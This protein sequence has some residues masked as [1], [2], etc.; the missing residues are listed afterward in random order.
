MRKPIFY[1]IKDE[2]TDE[3][4]RHLAR[5]SE[6]ELSD[7]D[8]EH[9][10]WEFNSLLD[11]VWKLQEIDTEWVEKMF[12]PVDT[13]LDYTRN[14][15]TSIDKEQAL[16]NSPQEVENNMIVIKSSTVEH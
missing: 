15:N 6:I 12:T 10:K 13:N 9:M 1:Y 2:M 4:I 11:F 14:A 8:L 7:E 5:L 16:K 3:Q